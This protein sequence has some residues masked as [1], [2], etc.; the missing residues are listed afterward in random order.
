MFVK[1]FEITDSNY[2]P[3]DN[4]HLFQ[5]Y[6]RTLG[7][8][9]TELHSITYLMSRTSSLVPILNCHIGQ[10]ILY[11]DL[12]GR[13]QKGWITGGVLKVMLE[14]PSSLLS[15]SVL[16]YCHNEESI[17]TFHRIVH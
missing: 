16:S 17:E 3:R 1:T 15:L 12:K 7:L 14:S 5:L 9:K 10:I 8:V 13:E 6:L 4:Q 2:A 11:L